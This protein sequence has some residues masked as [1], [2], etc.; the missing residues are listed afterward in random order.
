MAHKQPMTFEE[1]Q[2]QG[3]SLHA[4]RNA[5]MDISLAVAKHY[6][7]TSKDARILFKVIDDLDKARGLLDERVFAEY[8]QKA[9]GELVK[10]YYPG[11]A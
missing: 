4:A 5:L 6:G 8:P 1:H 9:T 10:V 2:E 11:E 3:K 7:K